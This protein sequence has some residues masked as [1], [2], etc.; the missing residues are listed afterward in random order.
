MPD[1]K[2]L[3]KLFEDIMTTVDFADVVEVATSQ[4]IGKKKI[5]LV[6]TGVEPDAKSIRY[7]LNVCERVKAGLDILCITS[8]AGYAALLEN[9]LKELLPKGTEYHIEKKTRSI[10]DVVIQ[11]TERS[12]SV[13]FVIM[14]SRGAVDGTSSKERQAIEEWKGLTCPLVLVS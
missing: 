12:T 13:Q 10:H 2:Y 7:A 14:D 1:R 6:L 11:Y 3:S 5:L 9:D 4:A 8:D